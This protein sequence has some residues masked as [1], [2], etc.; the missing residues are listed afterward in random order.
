[1]NKRFISLR[2]QLWHLLL[3][4]NYTVQCGRF[5]RFTMKTSAVEKQ[6][7]VKKLFLTSTQLKLK[8]IVTNYL[9]V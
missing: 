2:L 4:D 7:K 6:L 8:L 9:I 5:Q 3:K 1:M